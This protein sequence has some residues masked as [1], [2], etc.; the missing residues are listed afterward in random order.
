MPAFGHPWLGGLVGD[1]EAEALLG[2]EA[3][4]AAMLR[5]EAALA[6]AE[7][8]HGVI[9][10]AAA[11]AIAAAL[12][13]FV[14][15]MA[16]LRRAT[17]RDGV[18]APEL[19]RQLRAAVG[20][21]HAADL[22]FGATSQDVIDTALVLRLSALLPMLARRLD[23]V[24]SALDA[25]AERFGARPLMG[26]TRMQAAIPIAASDRIASWRDPLVRQAARLERLRPEILVVQFGGAAGTLEKLGDTAAAVRATLAAELGL[27]DA[28]QWHGQRDRIAELG[29]WLAVT[30]GALGKLG[31]DV[32]LMALAGEIA[33]SGGG[34]SSAMPHKANPV[35]AEILVALARF[36][37]AELGG[38]QQAMVHEQERSGAA[39]TLEWL[40]LPPML[41]A[42]AAALATGLRVVGSVESIG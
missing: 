19:V 16:A 9:A 14:P 23:G 36:T 15:D 12:A 5:F 39:W 22:H 28:P 34:A 26:R 4:L 7:A 3:E 25:L 40:V 32:A 31:Q 20:A 41:I 8:L 29:S 13:S 10:P 37:A 21:P 1:E 27:R 42:T 2:A 24:I 35:G 11:A 17:A 38:L 6:A 33:L 18:V 30:G